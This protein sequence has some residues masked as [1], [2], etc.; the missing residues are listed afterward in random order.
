MKDTFD[1]GWPTK[2]LGDLVDVLD[3]LR[4][5]ITKK[6][7]KAGP[8]PYYGAT[9]VLDHVDG[10]LF[11]EPLVLIG[12]D[13]AKWEAGA[14]SAFPIQGKTWVNNH[15]HVIRPHRDQVLDDW[16]I[17]YLNGAD[18]MPFISGMTVPKLNQGRLRGIP[19]PLPS[20]E[21]QQRIVA[22]LD[23][24]FEGL[25]RARAHA[26]ANLQNARKFFDNAL[27][28]MM[29]EI[30]QDSPRLSLSDAA[31]DFG[32]GRSRHRPRNAPFLY[33]GPY[34]FIQT[35]DIRNASGRL[36][37]FSQT[38]SEDG[39]A[40]SKL[41]PAG[42]VCITIAANIAETSVM[43]FEG[44]FP[45]SVIGMVPDDQVTFPEYVEYMLRY[46]AAGLK[47][48][49][50]GSAQDN[51]NLGTF[52]QA[53]FPFPSIDQQ[54]EVVSKLDA[55]WA[56]SS[57]MV[58]L[59]SQKITD[60]N[61]LRQSLLQKAFAGKLTAI[62]PKT[63]A[64]SS[65]DN[66]V[67]TTQI[68]S[69]AYSRH[70]SARRERTFGRVKAQ[71]ALHLAEAIAGVELGRNPIRDAAGPNDMAHMRQ[72]EAHAKAGDVFHF[73]QRSG[74]GYTFNPGSGLEGAVRDCKEAFGDQLQTLTKLIDLITPMDTVEAE[75]FATVYAGWNNLISDGAEISDEAIVNASRE[76]WHADKLNIERQKFFDAIKQIKA[77]GFEPD[78]TAKYVPAVQERLL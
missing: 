40:Q 59:Y 66:S 19:I 27:L 10:Y 20:V 6:D 75:V 36:T 78:G 37:E 31:K 71:K 22:V 73:T 49:G 41:W 64:V 16:L 33:G 8:Y 51:I 52:E 3:R 70:L 48:Q 38:Y 30:D 74:G 32:R 77:A 39:L 62:A 29:A 34:P 76:D 69:L 21:E 15:A 1:F 45:D 56:S 14:N 28:A 46:F 50:K 53:T 26:E 44:C 61:D 65:N 11:D 23:E 18:L 9:G 35:G 17:Y 7:R 4:K 42:T 12:E 55:L 60:L 25:A 58:A 5:P 68:L 67:R 57:D 13:G 47:A 63:S 24:A 72:A 54:R 43:C 2:P